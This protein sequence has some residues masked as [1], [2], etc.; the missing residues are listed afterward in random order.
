MTAT[1]TDRLTPH[2]LRRAAIDALTAVESLLQRHM[3]ADLA[4]DAVNHKVRVRLCTEDPREGH[5]LAEILRLAPEAPTSTDINVHH[6][7]S[8]LVLGHP[9]RVSVLVPIPT[10]KP[11]SGIE[12]VRVTR[13]ARVDCGTASCSERSR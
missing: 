12:V 11:V 13:G 9:V 3:E 4:I 5:S 2:D 1:T 10:Q 8:G 7:W 6:A